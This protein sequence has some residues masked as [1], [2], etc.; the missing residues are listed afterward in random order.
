MGCNLVGGELELRIM[1]RQQSSNSLRLMSTVLLLRSGYPPI[2]D[3]SSLSL[4][5]RKDLK[6]PQH[7]STPVSERVPVP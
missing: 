1:D 5:P 4:K 6:I 2:F 7:M 3:H